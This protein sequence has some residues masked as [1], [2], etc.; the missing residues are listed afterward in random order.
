MLVASSRASSAGL[1]PKMGSI[2]DHVFRQM[3]KVGSDLGNINGD[4]KVLRH[5]RIVM[6]I[7]FTL[8]IIINCV[9]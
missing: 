9:S 8:I 3:E 6:K 5:G 1:Y 2:L 4:G 7:P